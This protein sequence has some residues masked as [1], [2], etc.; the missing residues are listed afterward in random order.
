MEE[1]PEKLKKIMKGWA[2]MGGHARAAKLSKQRL[3]EIATIAS[4]AA[5]RKNEAKRRKAKD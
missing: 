4:H 5:K 1:V 2:A 3:V